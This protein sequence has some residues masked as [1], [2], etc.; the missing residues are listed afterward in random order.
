MNLHGLQCGLLSNL[1]FAVYELSSNSFALSLTTGFRELTSTLIRLTIY[2]FKMS[3]FFVVYSQSSGVCRPNVIAMTS[4][5]ITTVAIMLH[6][7]G[8][9]WYLMNGRNQTQKYVVRSKNVIPTK[10]LISLMKVVR[11]QKYQRHWTQT[12]AIIILWNPSLGNV[13]C[14]VVRWWCVHALTHVLHICAHFKHGWNDF[15]SPE[16]NE[17]LSIFRPRDFS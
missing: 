15:S 10:H 6:C 7:R 11:R 4:Q 16:K 3:V 17:S 2:I 5:S 13:V 12:F 1:F 8:L 14:F 9:K